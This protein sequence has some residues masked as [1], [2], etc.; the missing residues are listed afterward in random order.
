MHRL[1]TRN[2]QRRYGCVMSRLELI[3]VGIWTESRKFKR[4]RIALQV[5]TETSGFESHGEMS[6]PYRGKR[7]LAGHMHLPQ[8]IKN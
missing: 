1:N 4:N 3:I 8:N 7:Y 6:G 5:C 2:G